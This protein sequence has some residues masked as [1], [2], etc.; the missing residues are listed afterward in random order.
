MRVRSRLAALVV[1]LVAC[2]PSAA[3]ATRPAPIVVGLPP[4][5]LSG[6]VIAL[7]P[8]HNGGNASHASQIATPVWIGTAW[9]PCNKVGTSTSAGYPEHAFTF[10]VALRVKASLE[11]FGAT[12]FMTRTTDT[13]VG[14][15]IDVRGRFGESV[16]A[17]L[18]VSIH[19]DGAPSANHGFFVMKPGIVAGWTDDIA[20]RSSVLAVA[21]R[22]GL[23][24]AELA[25]A[26]YYA[27]NGLKTRTDLGTLNWSDVPVVELELGNM[28]NAG[29]AAR[30]SS[31]QGR[32]QYANGVVNGI[33]IYLGR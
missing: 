14:P 29:D 21:M 2:A 3:A 30:M 5:P 15:C 10:D 20:T 4:L 27:T 25:V 12:V 19:A 9:K 23:K 33:R 1:L 28:K 31:R 8:G 7:D 22:E 17:R 18:T 32:T 13:G 6:V 11:Y 26:N 16:G 24:D